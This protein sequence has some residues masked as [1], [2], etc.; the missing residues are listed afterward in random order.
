MTATGGQEGLAAETA[1]GEEAI[2]EQ[3]IQTATRF[4]APQSAEVQPT[5]FDAEY[6]PSPTMRSLRLPPTT[7]ATRR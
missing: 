3:A 2:Q 6:Q 4:D 5:G 7:G 1:T